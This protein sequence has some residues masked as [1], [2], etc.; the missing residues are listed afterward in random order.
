MLAIKGV[1]QLRQS[2]S[3]SSISLAGGVLKINVKC[4]QSVKIPTPEERDDS[5]VQ[6]KELQMLKPSFILRGCAY[7]SLPIQEE[8]KH[9]SLL[10]V[11]TF[12]A[13][14]LGFRA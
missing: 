9:L 7:I 11:S 6:Q 8:R 2:R 1:L 3:A 10:F 4:S 13:Q 5:N 12:I 14:T